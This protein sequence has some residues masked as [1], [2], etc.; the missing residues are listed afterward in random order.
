[1]CG[2]ILAPFRKSAQELSLFHPV[3]FSTNA[4]TCS[5]HVTVYFYSFTAFL[6]SCALPK[7]VLQFWGFI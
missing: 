7:P 2:L 1:M 3:P 4:T 6:A 5:L